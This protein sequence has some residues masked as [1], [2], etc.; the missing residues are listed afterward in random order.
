VRVLV[1][2]YSTVSSAQLFSPGRFC[3][4]CHAQLA[5]TLNVE[6]MFGTMTE[7]C[8]GTTSFEYPQRPDGAV[9]AHS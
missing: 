5:E 2:S 6:R 1:D 3:R 9:T 4:I 8:V 7:F